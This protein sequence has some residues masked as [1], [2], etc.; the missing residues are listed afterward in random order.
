[1]VFIVLVIVYAGTCIHNFFCEYFANGAPVS[2]Q[3]IK[4]CIM[5]TY[6]KLRIVFMVFCA[7]FLPA[8]QG[9]VFANGYDI[10]GIYDVYGTNPGGGLYGGTVEITESGDGYEFSWD[11]GESYG[12]TGS[13]GK[14]ILTV[15]WGQE[16]PVI[17]TVKQ[18]GRVLVGMWA[19]G[20]ATETLVRQGDA[21]G[22]I[23]VGG[24]YDVQGTT[25]DGAVYTGTVTVTQTGDTYNFS[26]EV[27]ESYTG[28]GYLKEG[29]M[30]VDWGDEYPVVYEVR[31]GGNLL[32]GL[33]ADGTAT[34]I[35]SR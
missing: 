35:L 5:D 23:K 30:T 1:M 18:G 29:K 31:Q 10:G 25:Q 13:L 3:L 21:S 20:A 11:V 2:Y 6:I 24:T 9:F 22:G 16:S 26:W 4:E 7:A 14:N 34:E 19:D 32:I 8:A 12:G 17:Y 15:D 27:G 33:W 28:T